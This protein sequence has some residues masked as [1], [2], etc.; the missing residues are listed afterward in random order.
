MSNQAP[1]ENKW[2]TIGG[3]P[4]LHRRAWK[5]AVSGGWET[6]LLIVLIAGSLFLLFFNLDINPRSWHD[7]GDALALAR[8]LVEDGFYGIKISDGFQTFGI[9]Q[10]IG[11][12][13]IIPAALVFKLFGVSLINGRAVAALLGLLTLIIFHRTAKALIGSRGALFG[14]MF[15]ISLPELRYLYIAR[16]FLGIVPALGFFLAGFLLWHQAVRSKRAGPA[17]LAGILLGG[18]TLTKSQYLVLG[19]AAF[20]ATAILDLIYYRLGA[21]KLTVVTIAVALTCYAGWNLWQLAYYGTE[22]FV[23][24]QA[25][26][27][28]LAGVAYGFH[29]ASV[30]EGIKTLLG[31]ATGHYFMY[32]GLLSL[33]YIGFIS[34]KKDP[35]SMGWML[36]LIFTGLSLGFVVFWTLP[37]IWHFFAPLAVTALFISKLFDDLLG[38]ILQTLARLKPAILELIRHRKPFP[39]GEITMVGALVAVITFFLWTGIN[40]KDRLVEDVLDRQGKSSSHS[41]RSFTLPYETADFLNQLVPPGSIIETSE[42]ELAILTDFIYHTPD[43]S[44]LIDVIPY[45]YRRIGSNNYQLGSE[46]FNSARADYLVI[47]YFARYHQAYSMDFISKNFEQI[48]VIGTGGFEYEVYRRITPFLD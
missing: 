21:F 2:T 36:L 37:W 8:A 46:Y 35:E 11:P 34:L 27:S 32:W 33:V 16:Q 43:Q 42:R 40:F 44:I 41:P 38:S 10:S 3:R 28:Q 23:E 17:I 6:I 13:V 14:I 24:N 39:T 18:A 45:I 26:M 30:M 20:G 9:V 1:S 25:K 48:K 4:Q 31:K 12:T 22:V 47:G 19:L 5:W 29:D 7:E 15:L